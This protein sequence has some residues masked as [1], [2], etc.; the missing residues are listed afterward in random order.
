[1]QMTLGQ[2]LRRQ[3]QDESGLSLVE[4]LIAIVTSLV[5]VAALMGLLV[6]SQHQTVLLRDVGQATQ[7]GRTAMT[8]IVDEL[9]SACLAKEFA[10]V[11]KESTASKLVLINAYSNE[12]EIKSGE[13][14]REDIIT[15]NKAKGT[16]TDE[17]LTS[18]G[19]EYP[20]FAFQ[21][22]G[23]GTR[24]VIGSNITETKQG[25]LKLPIFRY[26]EYAEAPEPDNSAEASSTLKETTKVPAEKGEGK[27]IAGVGI[28]FTATPAS[29]LE[30]VGRSVNLN[31]F[32]TLAF[33][34]PFSEPKVEDGPCR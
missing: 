8:R 20:E 18:T 7:S 4:L 10:P 9:H 31:T 1:M 29:G 11:Q 22:P 24:T 6:V 14:T 30:T 12:A 34:A 25:E 26:Y 17:T 21:A 33:S 15:F 27:T 3:L 23:K 13:R 5:V 19:G 16:L 32:A 28:A 2:R